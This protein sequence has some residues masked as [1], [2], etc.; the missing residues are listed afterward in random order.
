[1]RITIYTL[2]QYPFEDVV[3]AFGPGLLLKLT[4]PGT[5]L[6]IRRFDGIFRDAAMD[7]EIEVPFRTMRW[8]GHITHFHDGS[9]WWGFSDC[10]DRMPAGLKKWQH[11][12]LVIRQGDRTL[13]VDRIRFSGKNTFFTATWTVLTLLMMGIRPYRYKKHF[14]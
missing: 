1:M 7:F 10:G 14:R 9:R 6:S 4:P 11:T 13:I 3:R 2:V 5:K 12:H 8:T